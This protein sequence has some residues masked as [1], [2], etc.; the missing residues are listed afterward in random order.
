MAVTITLLGDGGSPG[1]LRSYGVAA[2]SKIAEVAVKLDL[3][4]SYPTGGEVVDLSDYLNTVDHVVGVALEG[5]YKAEYV[6]GAGNS[7]ALGK[8]LVRVMNTGAQVADTTDLSAVD[9]YLTV[10][11]HL[12]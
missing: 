2:G 4:A 1:P 5:D 3:D 6:F 9:V 7:A 12:K 11:G 10:R 8:V